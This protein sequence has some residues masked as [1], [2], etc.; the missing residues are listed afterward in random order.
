MAWEQ[1]IAYVLNDFTSLSKATTA[2]H[3]P[4]HSLVE[5]LS[6]R[7]LE[8]L[9]LIAAGL[10]NAEIAHRLSIAIATVK[11]HAGNIYSKLGVSNRAQAAVQAQK[12]D[13]I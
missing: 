6:S 13:L 7:E 5:P 2:D 11:V 9:T 1:A 3:K 4:T 12:F 8:V 10:T